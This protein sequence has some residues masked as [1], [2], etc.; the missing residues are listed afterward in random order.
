MND[1]SLCNRLK[2]KRSTMESEH[3][4][5]VTW[6]EHFSIYGNSGNSCISDLNGILN[7]KRI[8]VSP[9]HIQIQEIHS[10]I[11]A[12][13]VQNKFNNQCITRWGTLLKYT[14][15]QRI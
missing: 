9:Q 7:S 8:S 2:T 10:L 4:G 14:Y 1:S 6:N 15:L 5:N 11:N 13:M 3:Y 12:T